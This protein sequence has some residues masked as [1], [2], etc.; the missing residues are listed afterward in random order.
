MS[1]HFNKLTPAEAELLACLAEECGEIIQAV[2]KALRHG[3][4]DG[5]PYPS[6]VTLG[7]PGHP[8]NRQSIAHEIGNLEAV[9]DRCLV[10]GILS[11]GEIDGARTAKDHKLSDWTHHQPDSTYPR[12][13]SMGGR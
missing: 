2:G 10:A 3:L 12:I 5:S 9:R 11:Q 1:D 8:R 4:D 6:G 13:L 7:A